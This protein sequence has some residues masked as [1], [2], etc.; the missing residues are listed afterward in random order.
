MLNKNN[1]IY[2]CF[3]CGVQFSDEKNNDGFKQ[4]Q[5]HIKETHKEGRDYVVCKMPW[6]GACVR[7]LKLHHK[8]RH[9]H[10]PLPKKGGLLKAMIWRDFTPKGKKT[11]KQFK[12]G[13]HESTKMNRR[14]Y[15]RSGYEKTVFE[16]LDLLPEVESYIV[17]PFKIPYIWEGTVHEYTPDLI[18]T[19]RDG[20]KE[21]WEIKP[22]SQTLLE[23]N[24][25]KRKA[26][27]TACLTR[28][29]KFLF[30]TEQLI[31]KLKRRK[32]ILQG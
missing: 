11:R 26:A 3:V 29:W 27:E 16:C 31:N 19:F 8:L 9:P 30:I 5:T 1:K 17:E 15:Y 14:F 13:W 21:L 28:G 7:D 22:A 18:I 12:D 10:E 24:Q 25:C 23:Q 6:C 4:Y 32:K 20:H 2:Q